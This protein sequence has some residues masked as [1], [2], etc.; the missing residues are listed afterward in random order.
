MYLM[1]KRLIV[2]KENTAHKSLEGHDITLS[3]NTVSS[4]GKVIICI[5]CH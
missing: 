1:L 4:K 5:K 2:S 3:A